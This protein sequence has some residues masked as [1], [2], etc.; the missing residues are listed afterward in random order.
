MGLSG[1]GLFFLLNI[2]TCMFVTLFRR[3]P[4]R[5]DPASVLISSVIATLLFHLL[6]I[7]VDVGAV[8]WLMI[9]VPIGFGF[10]LFASA[11]ANLIAQGVI[12]RNR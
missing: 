6:A 4:R 7:S 1:L 5:I 9:S 10:S 12:R 8:M 11:V 2:V 3:A